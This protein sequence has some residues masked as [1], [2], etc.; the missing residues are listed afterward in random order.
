MDLWS[1]M[2]AA[3]ARASVRDLVVFGE[4]NPVGELVSGPSETLRR[5][6]TDLGVHVLD[7]RGFSRMAHYGPRES[8]HQHGHDFGNWGWFSGNKPGENRPKRGRARGVLAWSKRTALMLH[9]TAVPMSAPRF[10]G[11]PA[12]AGIAKDGTIVLMHPSDAYVWHGHAAN[13]FS[14]GVEISGRSDI[15]AHQV[16]PA[17]ILLE[18]L[19]ADRQQHHEA[20]MAVMAHRQSHRSRRNDPGIHVWGE[21]GEWGMRELGLKMGPTVGSGKDIP[22]EWRS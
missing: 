13:R 6:A 8:C 22:Q 20:T 14:I 7:L 3:L 12:H 19:V 11:V 10:L 16:E 1:K 2:S 21:L 15:Q 4:E 17:R 5:K 18:Y 9:T